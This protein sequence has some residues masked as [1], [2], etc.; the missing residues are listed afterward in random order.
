MMNKKELEDYS[1]AWNDHDI[2]KIMHFMTDDCVFETAGGTEH[3]GTRYVGAEEVKSRFIAVWTDIPDAQFSNGEHF[4]DGNR[5]CSEWTF[6]GTTKEGTSIK[7]DGCDLFTFEN[8]KIK[9]KESYL[10]N[11]S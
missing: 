3:Y 11:R 2:E 7:L 10:K 8:D 1:Q 6:T 5:G 9:R 4:V